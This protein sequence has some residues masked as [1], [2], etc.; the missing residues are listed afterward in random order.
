MPVS[1]VI[2]FTFTDDSGETATTAVKVFSGNV[3]A[4][5]IEA[6]QQFA[7]LFA[8]IVGAKDIK[9]TLGIQLDVSSAIAL[10]NPL[11][12]ADVEE[13]GYFG[14]RSVEGTTS[15]INLPTLNESLVLA[16]SD[17]IDQ[18]DPDVANVILALEQGIGVTSGA[19]VRTTD[20]RDAELDNLIIAEERFASRN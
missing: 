10:L 20:S 16:G 6:G 8:R 7:E 17:N 2:I 13:K 15:G 18:T 11:A 4:D 14:L 19:I 1:P 12:T 5:I 9:A 3:L